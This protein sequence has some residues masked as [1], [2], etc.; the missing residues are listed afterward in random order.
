MPRPRH[1]LLLVA[2]LAALGTAACERP[3]IAITPVFELQ[4]DAGAVECAAFKD[5]ACVNF[6]KFQIA[7]Q[8]DLTP[9]TEC[10]TVDQRLTTLCDVEELAKGTEIFRHA[11]DARVQIKMWGLRVFPATSC[12]IIPECPAKSLFSGATDWIKASEVQGGQLPL[13]ITE[14]TD[15]GLKEVYQLR[16]GRDCFT[17]C[18]Y[19]EPVCSMHDGCVCLLPQQDA[20]VPASGGSWKLTDGGID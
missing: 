10:I 11:K 16:G 20:G 12:E 9:S 6:I 14:A 7:E 19:T 5:L 18:D 13:H 3:R 8:G 17:V 15:C 4:T 2:A 1:L